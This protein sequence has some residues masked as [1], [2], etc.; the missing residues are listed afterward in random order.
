MIAD[1]TKGKLQ[2]AWTVIK[3][4][5]EHGSVSLMIDFERPRATEEIPTVLSEGLKID[6]IVLLCG[7]S[8]TL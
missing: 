7:D 8:C 5:F 6:R 2:S 4:L 1:R 3:F